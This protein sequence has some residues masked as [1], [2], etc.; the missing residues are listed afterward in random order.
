MARWDVIVRKQERVWAEPIVVEAFYHDEKGEIYAVR[1]WYYECPTIFEKDESKVDYLVFECYEDDSGR[2]YYAFI[3]KKLW[4]VIEDTL[5]Y[6][7]RKTEA[8]FYIEVNVNDEETF[9]LLQQIVKKLK[10]KYPVSE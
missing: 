2:D 1:R 3:G 10:E 4:S 8:D 6:D 9:E 5:D 7:I